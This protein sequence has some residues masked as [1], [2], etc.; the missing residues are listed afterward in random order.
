MD[1]AAVAA[2]P[3]GRLRAAVVTVQ[4]SIQTGG[5]PQPGYVRTLHEFDCA[6]QESRW[7]SLIAFARDGST[8]VKDQN[9]RPNW[10]APPRSSDADVALRALCNG[11]GGFSVVTG[12]SMGQL[13]AALMQGWD[14]PPPA[15]A[16]QPRPSPKDRPRTAKKPRPLR[17]T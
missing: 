4:R 9:P 7:L 16:P 5:Y 6:R 1:P 10:L 15:L 17:R 2:A 13:V 8:L 11:G 12:A 3:G 14:A